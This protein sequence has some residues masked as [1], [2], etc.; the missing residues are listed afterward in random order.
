[1]VVWVLAVQ[2][3]DGGSGSKEGEVER[4]KNIVH[5]MCLVPRIHLHISPPDDKVHNAP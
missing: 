5:H 3:S 2:V 1:M 4:K